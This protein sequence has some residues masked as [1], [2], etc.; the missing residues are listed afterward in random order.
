MATNVRSATHNRFGPV[1]ANCRFTRSAGCGNV[2]SRTVV[3]R[4]APRLTPCISSCFISRATVQRA[5]ARPFPLQLAPHLPDA[6]YLEVVRPYTPYLPAQ[7]PDP[8]APGPATA[9]GPRPGPY[10]HSRLMG[11]PATVCRFGLDPNTFPVLVDEGHLARRLAV[12]LRLGE[13]S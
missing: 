1:A 6:V 5:T 11:R 2:S 4:F 9:P 12:E 13:K 3:Q 8:A 10:A 7:R